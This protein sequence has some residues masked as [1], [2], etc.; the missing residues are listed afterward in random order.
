MP[1]Y[2]NHNTY[3]PDLVKKTS[4]KFQNSSPNLMGAREFSVFGITSV[5]GVP[6]PL[7]NFS[8]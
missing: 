4:I 2:A 7:Q 8:K 5:T 3:L 6:K 1:H